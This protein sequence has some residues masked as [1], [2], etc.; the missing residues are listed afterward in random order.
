MGI[1]SHKIPLGSSMGKGLHTI[2][3]GTGYQLISMG[4]GSH[5][6]SRGI[7]SHKILMGKG[8]FMLAL[9]LIR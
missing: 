8:Y 5:T 7:S 2:S 6:M 4:K 1:G 3:M 9:F